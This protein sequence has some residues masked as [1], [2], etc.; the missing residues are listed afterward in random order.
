[1]KKIIALLLVLVLAFSLVACG[2]SQSSSSDNDDDKKSEDK[3]KSE[4]K[5]NT[6]G[7]N[8]QLSFARGKIENNV[9]KNDF[10]GFEIA[11]EGS[12]T[13]S[14][15]ADIARLCGVTEDEI[16]GDGYKTLL[17]Q[18]GSML[19]LSASTS[20]SKLS[21]NLTYTY[22]KNYPFVSTGENATPEEYAGVYKKMFENE[23]A[24]METKTVKLSGDEYLRASFTIENSDYAKVYYFRKV[25]KYMCILDFTYTN[26]YTLDTIEGMIK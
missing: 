15:D 4:E 22:P 24:K 5:D 3:N 13:I 1:M 26:A 12:W 6:N 2:S 19:D 16:K 9:Y 7:G 20:D 10:I 25:G 18:F 14:S 23:G 17:E 21:V 11:M 8:K